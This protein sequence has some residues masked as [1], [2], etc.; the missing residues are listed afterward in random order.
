MQLRNVTI[1]KKNNLNVV[2][3]SLCWGIGTIMILKY[4]W[5]QMGDDSFIFFR[6]A[7]NFIEGHGLKWNVFDVPV[8][9]F[10]SPL[11]VFWL[12]I[13]GNWFDIIVVA[14]WSNVLCL[15][16]VGYFIWKQSEKSWWAMWGVFFTMGIQYWGTA[17]LETP[18]YICLFVGVLPVC[19]QRPTFTQLVILSLL[20]ITRPEGV[21]LVIL[22]VSYLIWMYR[23][24][25]ML[26]VLI[27]TV[28]WILVR[29]QYYGDILPNTYWAK[30]TGDPLF[31]VISGWNYGGWLIL[32]LLI[33]L[34]KST[35]KKP[36]VWVSTL[37]LVVIVGGGDWMWHDRLLL[38]VIVSV[39]IL[40]QRI[41]GWSKWFIMGS[42]VKYWI[43]LSVLGSLLMSPFSGKGL[44]IQY[45][46]EGNLIEVSKN[47]ANDI[48]SV[49]PPDSLIAINHAGAVPYFL[50]EHNFLDISGLNDRYL[51]KMEGN[52][53]EKYDAEYIL[54]RK[55]DWIILNSLIDPKSENGHFKPNYWQG[56]SVIFE[57]PSFS[58]EYVPIA[59]SWR[60]IRYGGGV[61]SIWLFRRRLTK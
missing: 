42:L 49:V 13:F 44:S 17:G 15:I 32:P 58:K 26:L 10:S 16:G 23:D 7:H 33:G 34:W 1:V 24:W 54:S 46:Q 4:F 60:R 28:F 59:Q 25:R 27:P 29:W 52:L 18:L 51:A 55:P 6:Y 3:M 21:G 40:S 37:W 48:R 2:L 38:P 20:G 39:W 57:H 5:D 14:Q 56:E 11:W 50:P 9:G 47:L 53:H 8:E 12:S 41:V 61:A 35:F 36:W 43:P 45:H 22:A 19:Y 31:R 30:A